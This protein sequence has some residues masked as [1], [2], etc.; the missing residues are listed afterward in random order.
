MR[1]TNNVTVVNHGSTPQQPTNT[2]TQTNSKLT[3]S[4]TTNPTQSR[5]GFYPTEDG[6][7][8]T[9]T[10][11]ILRTQRTNLT[12]RRSAARGASTLPAQASSTQP[13]HTSNLMVTQHDPVSTALSH[14]TGLLS[15]AIKKTVTSNPTLQP[16][17]PYGSRS[18]RGIFTLPSAKPQPSTPTLRPTQH[19]PNPKTNPIL[20]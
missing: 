10:S 2:T 14:C 19:Y 17:Q 16:N 7:T 13:N 6:L 18:P 1:P 11:I 12:Q 9:P 4:H 20:T 8:P 5:R 15:C 3:Y